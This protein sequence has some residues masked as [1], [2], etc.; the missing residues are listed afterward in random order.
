M[1]RY[2]AV[3]DDV[4]KWAVM[5]QAWNNLLF[6][7]WP[8][9]PEV[10]D[11]RLP[12]GITADV[13]GGTAWVGLAAFQKERVGA[14]RIRVPYLGNFP[15]TNVRTYVRGPDGR[16]GVWFD[17]LDIARLVP[18]LMSRLTYGLP[19]MWS[20]MSIA[21]SGTQRRYEC[22]RRFG[23]R[24]A[25]S[26][27]RAEIGPAISPGDVS[28]L[29]RFLTCRWGLYS[30]YASRLLYAP[31]EH[32]EWPLHRATLLDM[33]DELAWVA[34]YPSPESPPL[35]HWTP[36]VEV[37]IGRRRRVVLARR[38]ARDLSVAPLGS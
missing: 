3:T 27:I 36:G 13:F 26:S 35:V 2:P 16:P 9:S 8:V 33:E 11:Q 19:Y 4:V 10:V 21:E 15:E 34:G 25:T 29:E 14:T 6:V 20:K 32:P 1:S 38:S 37:R 31:V 12:R 28:P 30:R 22:R 18:A 7:H 17:S 5:R 24:G 23:G